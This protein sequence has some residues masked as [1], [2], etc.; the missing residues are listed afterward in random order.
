[1]GDAALWDRYARRYIAGRIRDQASYERKL[2]ETQAWFTPQTE[3]LEVGAGSGATARRHAPRVRQIDTIDYSAAM[4]AHQQAQAAAEGLANVRA[5]QS[6]L[7]DWPADRRY[8]VV[9]AM[10]V[11]HLLPDLQA[12]VNKMSAHLR[13]GG[14]LVTSTICLRG[15]WILRPV[16]AVAAAVRV[17]PRVAFLGVDDLLGAMM[18]AE[19]TI[20]RHWAPEGG[21]A[22][23]IIARK[24]GRDAAL[25]ETGA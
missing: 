19:L 12:A 11:L 6:S 1:M 5:A 17:A 13:P 10:S 4:V 22:Q 2:A 16:L 18:A 8:D 15:S 25:A 21:G 23:F 9:M 20:L 24:A 7:E 14:I 3:V